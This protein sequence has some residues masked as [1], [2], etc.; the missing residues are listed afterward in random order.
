LAELQARTDR[1]AGLEPSLD[2][3]VAGA[4]GAFDAL[5]AQFAPVVHGIVLSRV[6]AGDADDLTQDVFLTVHRKLGELRDVSALPGWICAIARNLATDRL[7]RRLRR[8]A[9]LPLDAEPPDAAAGDGA[10]LRERV[11]GRIRSLPDAYRD[12]LV[13]R[14][15][16]GLSGPEIAARTGMTHGSV[17]VNLTR[18]M[19]L[20]RDLLAKDGWP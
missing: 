11:L 5:Y 4:P 19:A 20:L 9:P 10:E 14:L 15:V 3:L 8:P 18:G 7:R 2:R 12:T 1:D 13:L 16:E 17:R 6:G